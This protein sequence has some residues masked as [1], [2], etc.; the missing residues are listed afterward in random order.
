MRFMLLM[1]PNIPDERYEQ[2][3]TADEVE[4][5]MQFN[6]ALTQAGVLLALDGLHPLSKGARVSSKNGEKSVTDGPF[7]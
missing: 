6:E 3:P 4:Q 1:I 2:G 7:T 5:M